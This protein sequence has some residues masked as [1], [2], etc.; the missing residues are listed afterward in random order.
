MQGVPCMRASLYHNYKGF[1]V[2][3]KTKSQGALCRCVACWEWG[4]HFLSG[5]E[6]ADAG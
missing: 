4:R 6:W 3:H 5:L 2:L 1:V